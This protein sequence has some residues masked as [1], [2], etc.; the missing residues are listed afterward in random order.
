MT[1]EVPW[2]FEEDGAEGG[3][4]TAEALVE[5]VAPRDGAAEPRE[6]A[7]APSE[8]PAAPGKAAL[9][10]EPSKAPFAGFEADAACS[11]AAMSLSDLLPAAWALAVA[12]RAF[13]VQGFKAGGWGAAAAV[14]GAG[15]E[16]GCPAGREASLC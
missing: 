8:G 10:T 4:P 3:A 16:E 6:G 9:P 2:G 14:L 11:S 12:L 1:G 7:A 15:A 5:A 13:A